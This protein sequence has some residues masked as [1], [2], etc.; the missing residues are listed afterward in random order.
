MT[1]NNIL[2]EMSKQIKKLCEIDKKLRKKHSTTKQEAEY[3]KLLA[4]IDKN[5]GKFFFVISDFRKIPKLEILSKERIVLNQA[6]VSMPLTN[7]LDT[8]LFEQETVKQ[9][10]KEN[11]LARKQKVKET[12]AKMQEYARYLHLRKKFENE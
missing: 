2:L 11:K 4:E 1:F 10:E 3:E 6:K 7:F 8:R 9:I 5:K 12:K